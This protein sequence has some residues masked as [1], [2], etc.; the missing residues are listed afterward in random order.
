MGLSKNRG[1]A[2][3]SLRV[4]SEATG[5]RVAIHKDMDLALSQLNQTTRAT[6]LLGYYPGDSNWDGRYRKIKVEV[7]RR[8]TKIFSRQGYYAR[9]KLQPYDREEFL[10]Y[11]RVAAA[12]DY[13]PDLKDILFKVTTNLEK[14]P[15]GKHQLRVE[16]RIDASKIQFHSVDGRRVGKLKIAVFPADTRWNSLGQDWQTIDMNLKEATYQKVLR[17]GIPATTSL[18]NAGNLDRLRVVVYDCTADKIGSTI[19]YLR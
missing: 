16:L 9:E 15:S 2:L 19:R 13:E 6:Y 12:A 8:G 4:I 17:E 18:P 5:G 14:G 3:A 10:S 11:S 7:K 1:W